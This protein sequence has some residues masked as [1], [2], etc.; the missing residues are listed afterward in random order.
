MH[1]SGDA[2]VINGQKDA[3]ATDWPKAEPTYYFR[4]RR[5]AD[6]MQKLQQQIAL[7][8][9]EQNTSRRPYDFL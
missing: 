8:I 6:S 2:S 4:G 1:E 7:T 3:T 5:V 9:D